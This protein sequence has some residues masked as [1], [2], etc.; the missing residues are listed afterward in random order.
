MGQSARQPGS[1]LALG[2]AY[3]IEAAGACPFELGAIGA[4]TPSRLAAWP[5][6][7]VP[8]R[9]VI[10]SLAPLWLQRPILVQ[11]IRQGGQWQDIN[12]VL[13]QRMNVFKIGDTVDDAALGNSI[14]DF[15]GFSRKPR[16]D[17]LACF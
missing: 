4:K 10:W 2:N 15:T 12:A 16:S 1:E 14:M 6:G 7:D 5:S 17:V 11:L 13:D 8:S 3:V 9:G